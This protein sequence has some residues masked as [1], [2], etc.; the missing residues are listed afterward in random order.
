MWLKCV[1]RS[2]PS[3]YVVMDGL[4]FLA[5]IFQMPPWDFLLCHHRFLY[6]QTNF[7]PI[8]STDTSVV[9]ASDRPNLRWH[10]REHSIRS[11]CHV[12]HLA[13]AIGFSLFFYRN[14]WRT[15]TYFGLFLQDDGCTVHSHLIFTLIGKEFAVISWFYSWWRFCSC[16]PNCSYYNRPISVLSTMY[17]ISTVICFKIYICGAVA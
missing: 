13:L 17:I 2:Y 4:W 10:T 14:I 6:L 9:N 15:Y 1:Y 8:A 7:C 16:C 11:W 3:W 12:F 5:P